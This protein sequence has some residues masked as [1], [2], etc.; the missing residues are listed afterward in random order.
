MDNLEDLPCPEKEYF[1]YMREGLSKIFSFLNPYRS[2][3][4]S[5]LD[6]TELDTIKPGDIVKKIDELFIG[7]VN[8]PTSIN[9]IIEFL[10]LAAT[11]RSIQSQTKETLQSLY[12][13]AT[14][15]LKATYHF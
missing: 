5:L 15:V 9:E 4:K 2:F 7:I 13:I 10:E 3:L 12:K 11:S 6:A 1:Q 14:V 8:S